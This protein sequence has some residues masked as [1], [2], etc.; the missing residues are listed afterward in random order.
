VSR[1]SQLPY[2]PFR[3]LWSLFCDDHARVCAACSSK[4][5]PLRIKMALGLN[6]LER[7]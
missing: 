1:F 3:N 7:I 6:R 5:K 2:L 4:R